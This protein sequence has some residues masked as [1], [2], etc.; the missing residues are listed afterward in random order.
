MTYSD[1]QSMHQIRPRLWLGNANDR[2]EQSRSSS[3]ITAFLTVVGHPDY[4]NFSYTPHQVSITRPLVDGPGNTQAEFNQAVEY[5]KLLMDQEH[6]VLVHCAQGISRS[7]TVMATYLA[8][9][10]GKKF[11]ESVEDIKKI[12]T[13]VNPNP[14]LAALARVYLQEPP[15]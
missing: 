14:A 13:F 10:E 9:V 5:L 2:K 7:T 1:Y 11:Y 8:K 12:R 3:V 4:Y 15:L 6:S